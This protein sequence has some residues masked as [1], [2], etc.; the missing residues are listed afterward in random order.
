[1]TTLVLAH[2]GLWEDMDARRFWHE[3]GIVPGLRRRGFRTLA[4]DRARRPPSWDAEVD[5]LAEALPDDEA[6]VVVA[7]SN[8]CSAAVRLAIAYPDRV[9][10]LLLA[11]PATAGDPAVDAPYRAHLAGLGAS[12][13]AVTA[14]LAGDTLRGVGDDELAALAVAVGVVPADP[15]NSVHQRRTVDALLRLVPLATELPGCPEPPRRDFAPRLPTFL[16]L[17]A[18]F[19]AA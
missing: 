4:P 8:G 9:A 16:D 2:G 5:H 3:P 17:V 19:A 10:K 11:W 14:L 1:M 12:S 15:A 13:T 18:A 7:G 6:A